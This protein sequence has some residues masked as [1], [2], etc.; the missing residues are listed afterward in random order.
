[1]DRFIEPRFPGGKIM[2]IPLTLAFAAAF[3]FGNAENLRAGASA[4]ELKLLSADVMKPALIELI[5]AFER[6]SGHKVSTDLEP[7]GAIR[8]R[9]QGGE[10]A[11]IAIIQRPTIEAL[12]KEGKFAADTIVTLARSGVALAVRKG[13]P[14]PD[15]SS[16]DAF[17]RA[18]LS[19]K[20]IGYPDPGR[21]MASGIH[22]RGVLDRLGIADQVN[23]KSELQ[24]G[25]FPDFVA[26]S[27]AEI[28]ITQPMEILAVPSL[29]LVGW[30]PDELQDYK[31]FTWAAAV[32]TNAKQPGAAKALIE[33]LIS[34]SA[35][36][37]INAKGMKPGPS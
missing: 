7:A 14:K 16:V 18:L 2:R 20:S 17:K 13:A 12:A 15:I 9:I 34:P 28:F 19:A 32:T 27:G 3:G 4:A 29:E 5:P 21:G 25:K 30:L 22:M 24:P 11:D 36:T 10:A 8:N 33:F 31:S 6:T 26:A 23:A 1:M 35:A 37:V